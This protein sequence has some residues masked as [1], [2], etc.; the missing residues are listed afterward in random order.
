MDTSKY[1]VDS[2][3]MIDILCDETFN[4]R[5]RVTPQM[6]LD[7]SSDIKVS[8]LDFPIHVQPYTARA[9]YKYRIVSGHRRFTACKVLNWTEI[10]CVIR[11]FRDE[12]EARSANLRENIQRADLNLVQEAEAVSW[13]VTAGYNVTQIA[14]KI[15][16]SNGWVEIRRKLLHL[17]GMVRQA[18][19]DGVITQSHI[20]QLWEHRQ[21]PEKLSM[22]LRT[23]KERAETG[24]RAI[25]VKEEVKLADFAKARRPKPH[26]ITDFLHVLAS[27]ITFKIDAPE[28]FPAR[29][30]AWVQG[31]ISPAQLYVSMKKECQRLNL[32]F[33]PPA[34]IKKIFD[35]I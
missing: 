8:G 21:N 2:I 24:E 25:V 12:A 13:Y 6:V 19:E 9:G 29:V 10:P 23:I 16:K 20:N 3:A 26:E 15:G 1:K 18:A 35:G 5:G 34:D 31:T 32:E 11:E 14:S 22:I 30:L 7:L 33:N 17:P 27:N 4:C 28:Y